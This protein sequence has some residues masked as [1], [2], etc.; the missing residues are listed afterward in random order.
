MN[1]GGRVLNHLSRKSG[2]PH[3]DP[4]FLYIKPVLNSLNHERRLRALVGL[5]EEQQVR[6]LLEV[7]AVA[8]PVV[9]QDANFPS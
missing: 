2:P 8:H 3:S 5:L 9:A 4:N 7:I 6:Q 1:A